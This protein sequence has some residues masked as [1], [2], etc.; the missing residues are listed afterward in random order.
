[1]I[2][3]S[4][5]PLFAA[6][7]A[8]SLV[9]GARAEAQLPVV[10]QTNLVSDDP[11]FNARITD[12]SAV[13][14]WGTS[15][16]GA[17]PFWVSDNGAGVA[18]LY[19]VSPTTNAPTKAGLTVSIPG[20]GSVSGQAFNATSA[21]NFNSDLFLFVSEDGTVSG[22]KGALGT[23]AETLAAGSAAN[24][25]KGAA[26]GTIGTN[27]YL[28]AANFRTGAVDVVKGNAGA[29]NLTGNFVDPNLPAGFAP[30]G[31]QRLGNTVYVTYAVQDAA[32]HDDV[33]GAGN[34]FVDAFD[35]NGNF[36]ARIASHGTL[37]SPWGLT[38][39]PSTFGLYSGDLLVGNFGDGTINAFNLATNSFVGQIGT[40]NGQPLVIDRLWA[41]TPGNGV[42]GGSTGM[43]FFTAGPGDEAHGLFG[44]LQA[45]PEPGAALWAL[46]A[47][48]PAGIAFRRRI[49]GAK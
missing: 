47:L 15:N 48:V 16:T 22:W 37:D 31:I 7:V 3:R 19:S 33:A 34:G 28:Y 20:D 9:L 30:F 14:M 5:R 25:Y 32:K 11:S 43:L 21:G 40:E 12:P 45:V 39:A 2:T 6:A 41:L 13:N 36:Q 49:R 46:A 10:R 8:A 17:S 44:S 38:I 26:Y 29:P 42:G 35:L 1:V 18:T 4:C 27:S 24:V 23:T